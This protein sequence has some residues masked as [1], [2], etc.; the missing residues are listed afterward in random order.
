MREGLNHLA[1]TAPERFRKASSEFVRSAQLATSLCAN[2]I[3][4][5][6]AAFPAQSE[7]LRTFLED[8]RGH[9]K[10]MEQS[11]RALGMSCS[12]Q[13]EAREE[14]IIALGTL[15]LAAKHSPFALACVISAFE[16]YTAQD[17]DEV[18]EAL[19]A[20]GY[21]IAAI[22]LDRH[23]AINNAGSHHDFGR[24]LLV[25]IHT[26][27]TSEVFEAAFLTLLKTQAECFLVDSILNTFSAKDGNDVA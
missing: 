17:C 9:D 10:L 6:L 12:D 19:K 14:A 4:P 15:A 7:K 21:E 23:L 24:G 25:T 1:R 2:L 16:G 20:N 11:L 22:G 26:V 18:A 8:E 13:P 3:S 27:S 5:A